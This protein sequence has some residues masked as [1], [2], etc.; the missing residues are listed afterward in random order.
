MSFIA[1]LVVFV[2]VV[3]LSAVVVWT[4]SVAFGGDWTFNGCVRFWFW[5]WLAVEVVYW[6]FKDE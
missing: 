6:F 4:I 5:V 3:L 2:I 1:N